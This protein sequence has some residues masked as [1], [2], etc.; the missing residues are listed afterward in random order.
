MIHTNNLLKKFKKAVIHYDMIL[1]EGGILVGLSGGKD[2]FTLLYLLKE[3][4]KYSKYK[5][6]LAAGHIGLGYEDKPEILAAFLPA[7]GCPVFLPAYQYRSRG[8]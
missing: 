3:F 5:Y 2:S 4:Q 7:A 8:F 1:D 6:T